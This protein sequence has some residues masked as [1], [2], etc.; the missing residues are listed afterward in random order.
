M[1]LHS[2]R[3]RGAAR[4][5]SA[6]PGRRSRAVPHAASP[7]WIA[8]AVSGAAASPFQAMDAAGLVARAVLRCQ[9]N[10]IMTDPASVPPS[11]DGVRRPPAG[12]GPDSRVWAWG[13]AYA[14]AVA[15][16]GVLALLN[17][18]ATG[19]A[20][21]L[22]LGLGLLAYGLVAI[23]AGVSPG[24]RR[25]VEV[26]LGVAALLA[27]IAV[28]FNP[29]AGAVSLVWAFGFWLLASGILQF[30]EAAREREDRAWRLLMS[31]IDI[32]LGALLLFSRPATGLAFLAIA[33]GISFL[34]RGI[35]LT[36]IALG[37]RRR[38]RL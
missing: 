10:F 34:C 17:P 13:L 15:L 23:V 30:I 37:L 7:P 16:I 18:L 22:L 4:F 19:F 35:Y 27:G 20:T 11:S 33:V 14:L 2:A 36:V 1:R 28:L 38:S 29:F 12:P 9:G 8:P 32:A 24:R 31:L 26:L 21:G 5:A 25:R 6:R 3:R